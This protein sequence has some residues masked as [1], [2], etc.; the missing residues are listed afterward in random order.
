[1]VT[2]AA[3]R[4]DRLARMEGTANRGTRGGARTGADRSSPSRL[5]HGAVTDRVLAAFFEVYKDLGSG[6]LESVYASALAIELRLRG[7]RIETQVPV[8]VHYRDIEVG[9]FR[10]DVIVE[11][12]VLVELKAADRLVAVH[13]QQVVNYLKATCLE[14][15]LLLNFGPSP[16]FKRLVLSNVNKRG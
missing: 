12:V 2:V 10:A 5:L 1:M 6:F 9:R 11:S 13:E 4:M 8:T 15:A 14:V 7:L 16:T 3:S